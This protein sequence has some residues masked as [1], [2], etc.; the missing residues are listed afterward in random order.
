MLYPTGPQFYRFL[1]DFMFKTKL[2]NFWNKKCLRQNQSLLLSNLVLQ[3]SNSKADSTSRLSYS[4][5]IYGC[6][7]YIVDSSLCPASVLHLLMQ[8]IPLSILATFLKQAKRYLCNQTRT[9]AIGIWSVCLSVCLTVSALYRSSW[10]FKSLYCTWFKGGTTCVQGFFCFPTVS[11]WCPFRGAFSGVERGLM[12]TDQFTN[13]F[14]VL[15][16]LA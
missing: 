13:C 7:L 2:E 6:I 8:I 10:N 5:K 1:Y 11:K 3:I 14:S 15:C 9:W 4:L 12:F 16:F